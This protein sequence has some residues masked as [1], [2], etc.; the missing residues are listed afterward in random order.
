MAHLLLDGALGAAM[1]IAIARSRDILW[2]V[3]IHFC[4]DMTQFD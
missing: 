2:F 4:L 1:F 3:P